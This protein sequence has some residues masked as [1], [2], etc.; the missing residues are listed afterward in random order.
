MAEYEFV[1]EFSEAVPPE[2]I[3]KV[4]LGWLAEEVGAELGLP[5]EFVDAYRPGSEEPYAGPETG[6]DFSQRVTAPRLATLTEL[7]SLVRDLRRVAGRLDSNPAG[8]VLGRQ[9]PKEFVPE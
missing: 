4:R 3:D 1:V 6:P 7:R 2:D 9:Q 8:Y 5:A